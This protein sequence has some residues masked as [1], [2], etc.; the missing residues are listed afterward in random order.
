M[1]CNLNFNG[2]EINRFGPEF[3]PNEGGHMAQ[4]GPHIQLK[5]KLGQKRN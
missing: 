4:R 1:G 2:D 5:V 3:D